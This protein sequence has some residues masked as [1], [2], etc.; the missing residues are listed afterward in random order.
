MCSTNKQFSSIN[1]PR[2]ESNESVQ[3]FDTLTK[4][5]TY[6]YVHL[7]KVPVLMVLNALSIL[8]LQVP[9]S[10]ISVLG[11]PHNLKASSDKVVHKWYVLL[12]WA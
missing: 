7:G 11:V 1:L 12:S 2:L 10:H 3:D 8:H 6:H 4:R 5:N 9:N